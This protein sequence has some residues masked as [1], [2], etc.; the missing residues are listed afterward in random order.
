MRRTPADIIIT[1]VLAAY[2]LYTASYIPGLVVAP[3]PPILL[4]GRILEAVFGF[5]SA[6]GVWTGTRWAPLTILALGLTIALMW[7]IEAFVLGIV[8]Y[9][10]AVAAAAIV[11]ILF[12]AGA[13]YVQ[14]H[15]H[16]AHNV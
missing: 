9:L 14:G 2:G 1:V 3:V 15:R 12:M 8:A 13:M 6:F 4:I 11:A 16:P 10:N 7:L 5:A